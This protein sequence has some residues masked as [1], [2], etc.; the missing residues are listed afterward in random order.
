MID[1]WFKQTRNSHARMCLSQE[2]LSDPVPEQLC[3]A[4]YRS[5]LNGCTQEI[6]NIT[7]HH[8]TYKGERTTMFHVMTSAIHASIGTVLQDPLSAMQSS[9]N[10]QRST[11][12]QSCANPDMRLSNLL[13][14]EIEMNSE[15]KSLNTLSLHKLT[16]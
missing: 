16:M 5:A 14:I 15:I 6:T 4:S 12:E 7:S 11:C 1:V 2:S 10:G 13:T 3:A 9:A 8:M